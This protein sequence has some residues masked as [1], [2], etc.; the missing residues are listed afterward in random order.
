MRRPLPTTASTI[1]NKFGH[2]AD[3]PLMA[4]NATITNAASRATLPI[5]VLLV[6]ERS[7]SDM[8]VDHVWDTFVTLSGY[9]GELPE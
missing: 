7:S 1:A 2:W 5:L 9:T 8:V 3:P 6:G 4:C